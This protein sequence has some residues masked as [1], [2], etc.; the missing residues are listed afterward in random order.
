MEQDQTSQHLCRVMAWLPFQKDWS[1][2][3]ETEELDLS[4]EKF[5]KLLTESLDEI[6]P[7][8]SFT[9]KSNYIFG[10]SDETKSLMKSRDEARQTARKVA[11]NQKQLWPIKYR[12]DPLKIFLNT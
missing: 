5:T 2:I 1:I 7:M 10:I 12:N 8:R 3:T 11:A 4:V 9:V 6:A